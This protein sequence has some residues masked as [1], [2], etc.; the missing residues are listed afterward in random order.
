MYI[1]AKSCPLGTFMLG[2]PWGGDVTSGTQHG[3]IQCFSTG[4]TS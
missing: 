1:N 4:L 2:V 3:H